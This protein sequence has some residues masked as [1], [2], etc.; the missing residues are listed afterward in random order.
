MHIKV[1]KKD[2]DRINGTS[3]ALADGSGDVASLEV[4]H[5]LHCLVG[6]NPISLLLIL[7]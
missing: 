5:D 6:N 3:L 1:P 7:S 4:Y 2:I